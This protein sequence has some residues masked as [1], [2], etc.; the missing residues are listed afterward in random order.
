MVDIIWEPRLTE[1]W[2][3]ASDDLLKLPFDTSDY[4]TPDLVDIGGTKVGTVKQLQNAIK[5]PGIEGTRA[6]QD[7][8]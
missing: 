7:S 3:N 2:V 4:F 1:N 5:T 8:L 6:I